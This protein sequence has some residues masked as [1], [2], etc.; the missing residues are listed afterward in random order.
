[1]PQEEKIL[2][3]IDP[4]K[5]HQQVFELCFEWFVRGYHINKDIDDMDKFREQFIRKFGETKIKL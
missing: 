2:V 3:A 5:V 1:M 4:D